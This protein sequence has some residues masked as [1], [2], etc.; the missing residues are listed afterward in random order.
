[1][2][3]L[4]GLDDSKFFGE[5]LRAII[6]QFRSEITEVKVLHVLQPYVAL[7]PP[8]MSQ[9]YA[10]ELENQKEPARALVEQAADQLRTAGFKADTAVEVGDVRECI[11]ASAEQWQADLIVVGSHG[12]GGIESFLL[13]NV[14]ESIARHAKCSVEIVRI[15]VRVC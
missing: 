11:L 14:A 6:T 15:P 7:T 2:R 4:L 1:M 3:I 10:P 8:E 5:G 9:G 13:G 12:Q